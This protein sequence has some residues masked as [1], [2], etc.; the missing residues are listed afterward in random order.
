MV[1]EANIMKHI[2]VLEDIGYRIVGTVEAV[3]G[4]LYV[5]DQ[6]EALANKCAM[7]DVLEC[8]LWYQKGDGMHQ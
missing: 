1:S 5:L 8:N 3:E 6:A 2:Q 4:E 7:S